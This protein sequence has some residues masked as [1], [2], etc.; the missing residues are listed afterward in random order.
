MN[1][2]PVFMATVMTLINGV[3]SFYRGVNEYIEDGG[4]V[5]PGLDAMETSV[6]T[7]ILIVS[8]NMLAVL[9][10]KMKVSSRESRTEIRTQK[11]RS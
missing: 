2:I 10:T 7:L 6:G 1:L 5:I 9:F 3:I 11:S 4:S 8:L